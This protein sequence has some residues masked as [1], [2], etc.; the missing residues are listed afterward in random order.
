MPQ[1]FSEIFENTEINISNINVDKIDELNTEADQPFSPTS[2]FHKLT[3]VS[4]PEY[5]EIVGTVKIIF[6]SKSD[7]SNAAIFTEGIFSVKTKPE[8][9]NAESFLSL[10]RF[11]FNYTSKIV[12][13]KQL[14]DK[15]GKLFT[16]PECTYSKDD[17]KDLIIE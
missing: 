17:F 13:E 9:E 14:A 10:I 3:T 16:V 8:A 5:K 7:E 1:P 15:T 4:L 2:V 12:A 6:R 11:I